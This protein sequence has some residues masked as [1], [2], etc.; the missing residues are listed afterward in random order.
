MRFAAEEQRVK[1]TGRTIFRDGIRYLGYTGTSIS[2]RFSGKTAKAKLLS[3]AST[4]SKKDYAWVA[5]YVKEEKDGDVSYGALCDDKP[6]KRFCLDKDEAE[7]VLYDEAEEKTVTITLIKY[8][9]AEYAACGIEWI[10]TDSDSV[11]EPPLPKKL[12]IEMIGD[13]ITC[14]YGNEGNVDEAEHDTS[15]ENPMKAYSLLTATHLDA[16]VNVVAWNGKGVITA[17]IG[18]D[19]PKVKDAGWLVPMLYEY[20]DAGCERDYLHTPVNEWEKWDDSLFVPDLITVYL[21]TNDASYTDND[22]A[23]NQEFIDGY[24]KFIDTIKSKNPDIPILCMLGTMDKRLCK[25]VADAVK[26][27]N[28]KHSEQNVY[29]LD[30]PPQEDADGIGINW[31]PTEATHRK[32]ASI[33]EN[34]IKDILS[35]SGKSDEI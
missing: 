10:E 25:S 23:R 17:Y 9:E 33:V 26:I 3:D 1:V 21:G 16:D 32:A 35:G 28:E 34:R 14:G 4:H 8:S 20:V 13:S 6:Y 30:L 31:H 7:Y 11:L 5:V 27:V 18:D 19:V 2:F 22:N 15:E 29:Y 24:V 12:K